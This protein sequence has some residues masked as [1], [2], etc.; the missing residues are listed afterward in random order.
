MELKTEAPVISSTQNPELK[1]FKTYTE[2]PHPKWIR[3]PDTPKSEKKMKIKLR[4]SPGHV[5]LNT[6]KNHKQALNLLINRV[7]CAC[8]SSQSTYPTHW[9]THKA[10]EDEA[11]TPILNHLLSS[12]LLDHST[13]WAQVKPK[14]LKT[15]APAMSS[16]NTKP[17]RTHR[18][19]N[20]YWPPP[21]QEKA[22]TN[23][24][25]KSEKTS[26][27]EILNTYSLSKECTEWVNLLMYMHWT[28]SKHAGALYTYPT[29]SV[30]RPPQGAHESVKLPVCF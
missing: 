14:E 3:N 10:A 26:P 12:S 30:R 11:S 5:I 24:P 9:H 18:H 28:V 25:Q 27:H 1:N 15:E 8:R 21:T 20:S 23:A 13:F 17:S 7:I 22:K 6:Y 29:R 19:Q 4:Q 2:P 16:L